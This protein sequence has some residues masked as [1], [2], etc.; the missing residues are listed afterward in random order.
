[1][2]RPA[3]VR[4]QDFEKK[5]QALTDKLLTFVLSDGVDRPSFRQLAIAAET[6]EPTLRHYFKD[7][8]GLIVHLLN[9]I[10]ERSE[11]MRE[12]LRQPQDNLD[13]A[14]KGYFRQ[15][16]SLTRTESYVKVHA[17]GIREAMGDEEI[18]KFYL[19]K[20]LS[21]GIDA[22]AE[23]LIRSK[24]GPKSFDEARH[25]AI[26]IVSASLLRVVHQEVLRGKV[27]KPLDEDVYFERVGEWL[28]DGLR[29]SKSSSGE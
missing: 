29:P 6:S 2:A 1:M 15:M 17:F 14:V 20:Y 3:G 16:A 4:N 23:R 26:L 27:H 22:V 8:T 11:P 10:N 13:D 19:Q 9:Q 21:S 24:G 18:Q 7:R 28:L 25:A 12:I 5:K